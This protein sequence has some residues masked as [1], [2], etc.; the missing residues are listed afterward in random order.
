MAWWPK[1]LGMTQLVMSIL[2]LDLGILFCRVLD[3]L[4]SGRSSQLSM[5]QGRGSQSCPQGLL[6]AGEW[7]RAQGAGH[8]F[9]L[10]PEPSEGPQGPQGQA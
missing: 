1:S 7:A 5:S 8:T 4:L 2:A 3:C 6:Q 9:E 10:L